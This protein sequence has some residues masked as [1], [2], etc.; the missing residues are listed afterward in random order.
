MGGVNPD[1]VIISGGNVTQGFGI[2][3][4][5]LV[6]IT[7]G[8]GGNGN[9]T[10]GD[11]RNNAYAVNLQNRNTGNSITYRDGG[12]GVAGDNGLIIRKLQSAETIGLRVDSGQVIQEAYPM[13][14]TIAAGVI[15]GI[16]PW[17][18]YRN[19]E[20]K[21]QSR[22]IMPWGIIIGGECLHNN[23]HLEPG[24]PRLSRRWFEFDIGWMWLSV[25]RLVGLAKLR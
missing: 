14:F 7:T 16:G 13:S 12:T 8:A 6:V 19:G 9:I 20:T 10:L 11:F 24:N 1:V 22:N 23:H 5:E 25:F 3:A 2:E 4:D 15:N 21:D 17:W 18:G